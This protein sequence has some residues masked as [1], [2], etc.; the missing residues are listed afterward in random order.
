[1]VGNEAVPGTPGSYYEGMELLCKR[2][3][4]AFD[5][6]LEEVGEE[7]WVRPNVGEIDGEGLFEMA[8]GA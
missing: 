3:R 7:R 5:A 6:F 8:F 4:V 1:M 2:E